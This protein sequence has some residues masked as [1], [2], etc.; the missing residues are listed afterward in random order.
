MTWEER[1]P[2]SA[3]AGAVGS[4][5]TAQQQAKK[6]AAES[7]RQAELDRAAAVAAGYTN[8]KTVADTDEARARTTG[9]ANT[10]THQ[11]ADDVSHGY[12]LPPGALPPEM[13]SQAPGKPPPNN[14]AFADY[15]SRLGAFYTR[16]KALDAASTAV[17]LAE[18]YGGMA[19]AEEKQALAVKAQAEKAFQDLATQRHWSADLKQKMRE[20]LGRMVR[21]SMRNGTSLEVATLNGVNAM[22]RVLVTQGHED[23]RAVSAHAAAAALHAGGGKKTTAGERDT[24]SYNAASAGL[25]PQGKSFMSMLYGTNNQPTKAQALQA[26]D[27][28]RLS[29]ADKQAARTVIESKQSL[30]VS[31]GSQVTGARADA[32]SARTGANS[33]DKFANLKG[34][35]LYHAIQMAPAFAPLSPRAKSFVHTALVGYGMDVP[36]A[37]AA[38]NASNN[39][40]KAAILQALGGP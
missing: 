25:T 31:P 17:G 39:P 19:A 24:E 36:A 40:D 35:Q 37:I 4:F 38:V 3:A 13:P 11:H 34:E 16:N 26:L 30:F 6:D 22:A 8:A 21:E 27:Q 12:I 29:P 2:F 14:R 1:S 23:A 10:A 28:S 20:E 5:L 9:L 32:N 15:Y 18:K 33:A 7:A